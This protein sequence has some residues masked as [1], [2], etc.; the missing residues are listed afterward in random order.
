MR[1]FLSKK[2]I[3]PVFLIGLSITAGYFLFFGVKPTPVYDKQAAS[4]QVQ[5][6]A[7]KNPDLD[8]DNDGLKD[9]EETLWKT[10]PHNPDTDGDGTPDGEEI[11]QNRNPAVKGPDD[12]ILETML[13]NGSED[14]NPD[15]KMPETFT[16]T[17]G[18]QFFA[19]FLVN[20]A[21]DGGKITTE[22]A[23]DIAN[24][25]LSTMDQYAKPGE[26]AYK[27]ADLK[28]VPATTE[29]IKSYGNQMGAIIKKYFD[30]IS[31]GEITLLVQAVKDEDSLILEKLKPISSAYKNTTEEAAVLNIPETLA[32]DHLVI[33][34]NFYQIAKEISAME[35]AFN[36]PALALIALKQYLDTSDSARTALK[37]IQ[38]NFLA[39][40]ITFQDN[41]P[42][43]IF[44]RY[45]SNVYSISDIPRLE[46]LQNQENLF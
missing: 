14:S 24:S 42:G 33:I 37:A 2:I 12:G 18:Q 17:I 41:E 5:K 31:E 39:N 3:I 43:K 23:N 9:W 34:N 22:N 44:S 21:T 46:K 15:F 13:N 36:D 1:H 32:G 7:L 10:D 4:L 29:N 40:Q 38:S 19:Q 30:P 6:E 16:E 28:T 20:K 27:I 8:N 45:S 35:K 26:N 25:M 11:K